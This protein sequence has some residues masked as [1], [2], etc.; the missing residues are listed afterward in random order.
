MKIALFGGSFNPPHRG[1]VEAAKTVLRELQ[2]DKLLIMPANMP[3]HK[4]LDGSSPSAQDRLELTR[5]AFSEL[6]NTEVTDLEL[7][8]EGKSYTAITVEE[9]RKEYPED[10]LML[11]MGTDMLMS[12]EEWY[13]FRYLLSELTLIVLA[14]MDGDERM[15]L[16]KAEQL[17][18]DYGAHVRLMR[19]E[20]LTM[21]STDIRALLRRRAGREY[22]PDAVYAR[23]VQ[24]HYYDAQPE[25]YWLREQAYAMLKPKRVAHVAGCESEAVKLAMH[26]GEDPED[27]AVAG[28]LHDITK[29]LMLEEQLI[30]CEEYGIINDTAETENLK[31]LHA[32]T[33][34]AIAR[35]RFGVSDRVY[36][37][38][39]WHTTGKPD[40]S[41][42]EKIIYMADYIEP[43]RDF[44]GVQKLRKLAYEDLDKAMEL[45]LSMSLDDIRS[46]GVE[47]YIDTVKAYEWYKEKNVNT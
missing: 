1:H 23:I 45:G 43:T 38:I 34:A 12:F 8:R 5:L 7:R 20:P 15:L 18:R 32:K 25:L 4:E 11:V 22:L 44:E 36:E 40:M 31:L 13:R 47:P 46:Y 2:P 14:R 33:G 10:E 9:L 37:A 24:K 30:L 39:R 17:R 26:W 42:L 19:H 21:S 29:K 6:Q 16:Q 35:E 27:A 3:P 41:L 28:I